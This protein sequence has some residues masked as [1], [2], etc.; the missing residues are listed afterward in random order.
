MKRVISVILSVCL[1]MTGVFSISPE[2][3]KVVP[4]ADMEVSAAS[5][6][7]LKTI[8]YKPT[9]NKRNDMVG[10]ARTQIDYRENSGNRTYFGAWYGMNGQP[11]CAMFVCWC[12]AKSGV[13]TTVIPKIA[14]A[15]RGWAKKQKVY[16]RS[17]QWGE[18]YIPKAGDLIYFSWS[19]R[20]YADHIGM[21]SGT[22]MK[23]G[24]R[25][26][27]TIEGNKHDKVKKGEYPINNK[28]ILGYASPKYS[29]VPTTTVKPGT[30]FT[31]RY[32]SNGGRNTPAAQ[33]KIANKALVLTK[34]I[35]TRM[36]FTFLG[37]STNAK[38]T[39]PAYKPGSSFTANKSVT[40]Y[41][42]WKD[43]TFKIRPTTTIY[44]RT[45][46]G[47]NY[48]AKSRLPKGSLAT[49]YET[50]DGW[51]KLYDGTWI[52][53][54]L[55]NRVSSSTT[56]KPSSSTTKPSSTTTPSSTG[57]AGTYM[58]TGDLFKRK[59]P[60]KTYAQVGVLK[61]GTKVTVVSVSNGWA[62]LSDGNWSSMNYLKKVS[63]A[64]SSTTNG[65][66]KPSSS[67][68][69]PSSSTTK[70]ST[71]AKPSTTSGAGTYTVTGDLFKRKGPGK[72]Y[73]QVGV[74]KKGTKVTVVSVS[75]GW[76]KLSDGNWSSMNY[77]KKVSS[78]PSSTTKATTKASTTS[79][80]AP[81]TGVGKTFVVKIAASS[82]VNMRLQ[83]S[84]TAAVQG[85]LPKDS[86][87]TINAVSGGW[88]RLIANNKWILLCNTTFV[89]GYK[90]KVARSDIKM[91]EGP[92]TNYGY[93]TTVPLGTYELSQISKDG[94]WGKLKTNG[95]WLMLSLTTRI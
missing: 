15:D 32:N 64:P 33:T 51:G 86:K 90:V 85:T 12:A 44:R 74:L 79:T 83:P 77:L 62:K 8:N 16:H 72:T 66:T 84:E 35:P 38:A 60:G 80:T 27:Y 87:A 31:I 91:R 52:M 18:N 54:S 82:G 42:I 19:V 29:G 65:T 20:D 56:T 22:G 28:Y 71:T 4:G 5:Y 46:P 49:V 61:K 69:K 26:V 92:G 81:I 10:F 24:V 39:T 76:A 40:L 70:P 57:G 89:S 23:N 78:A 63:S 53:L 2:V 45:G 37:W 41:A 14:N 48:P 25:Y 88:G 93:K 55:T 75:N 43:N 30:K 13:P 73:A 58:V 9:G 95:K 11:W 21:V 36:G 17:V 6:P 67:T 94:K 59:G 1:I 34:G 7:P 47:K 68:T 3:S 50:K